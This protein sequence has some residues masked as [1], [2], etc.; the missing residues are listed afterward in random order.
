MRTVIAISLLCCLTSLSNAQNTT[1][2]NAPPDERVSALESL[3]QQYMGA[4]APL[5]N[6]AIY[7]DY[8]HTISGNLPF[9]NG[10]REFTK[11]NIC[12]N[13][14]TYKD[15][16]IAYDVYKDKLLIQHPVN[17]KI[18][19][20]QPVAIQYFELSGRRFVALPA[21]E[22]GLRPGFYELIYGGLKSTVYSKHIKQL[23]QDLSEN[24][25]RYNF[26]NS[27]VYYVFRKGQLSK[28]TNRK[29]LFQAYNNEDVRSFVKSN[30]LDTKKDLSDV[31]KSVA[32]YYDELY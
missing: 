6:G 11:G 23:S 4:E 13:D 26:Q 18:F 24:T 14:I 10:T 30:N 22:K 21:L 16:L 17:Y 12:F 25:T 31:L 5:F 19:E 32:T 1:G 28:V 15:V 8:T 2:K 20:V 27:N 29:S 9:W 3:Y 7:I